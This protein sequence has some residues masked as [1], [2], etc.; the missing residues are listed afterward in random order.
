MNVQDAAEREHSLWVKRTKVGPEQILQVG[1]IPGGTLTHSFDLYHGSKTA[2]LCQG[3]AIAQGGQ[4]GE[5][6]ATSPA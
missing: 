4:V 3:D 6:G 5:A 2:P 1:Q